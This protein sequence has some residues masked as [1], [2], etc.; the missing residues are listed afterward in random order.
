MRLTANS[1]LL[2]IGDSITDCQRAKPIGAG[3]RGQPL[4]V[5]YVAMVDALIA[6]AYP[7]LH[8]RTVNM[9]SSGNRVRDLKARW[10][11]DVL[12]QHPDWVTV[13]IGI[14]DVWRQFDAPAAPATGETGDD[15]VLIGEYETTLRELVAK[16]RPQVR[17][18]V[19]LTPF[20]LEPNPADAMRAMMDSYGAA[21]RRIATQH[22]CLFVDVQAAFNRV[23]THIYPASLAWDRVHPA[24][25]GHMVIAR[26][27]LDALG[28]DWPRGLR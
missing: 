24:W 20:Y 15:Q 23:L 16:T 22:D 10:Q 14:N 12:D 28:F 18:M 2:M 13:L 8:I 3:W 11:S 21:V 9:G 25:P 4:G 6:A 17:G 5:G 27:L 26:A 1:R 7:E 19:L